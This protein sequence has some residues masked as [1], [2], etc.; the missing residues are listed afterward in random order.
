MG[1]GGRRVVEDLAV[2]IL[3]NTADRLLIF[4]P[5]LITAEFYC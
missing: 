2:V 3:L 4:R 1:V 5:L